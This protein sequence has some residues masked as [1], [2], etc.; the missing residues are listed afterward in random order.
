EVAFRELTDTAVD[1]G[2]GRIVDPFGDIGTER[3]GDGAH[4]HSVAS[5]APWYPHDHRRSKPPPSTALRGRAPPRHRRHQTRRRRG[6]WRRTSLVASRHPG[7]RSGRP[8]VDGRATYRTRP[9]GDRGGGHRMVRP[10]W[11][12]HRVWRAARP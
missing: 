2:A 9:T 1:A 6:D 11:H 12:R 5:V 3:V 10:R 7:P 4:G 8:M